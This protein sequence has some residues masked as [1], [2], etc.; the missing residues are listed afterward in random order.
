M[1]VFLSLEDILVLIDDLGVGPIRDIGLLN[2]AIHRTQ[3]TAF[4]VDAYRTLG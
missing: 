1:T 3:A 2:S 4:G